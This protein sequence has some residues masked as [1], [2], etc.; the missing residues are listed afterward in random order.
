[1]TGLTYAPSD[2][3]ATVQPPPELASTPNILAAFGEAVEAAGL[4]GESRA[5]KLCYL[6]VTTRLLDRP[7]SLAL[8]GPSAAGKSYLLETVLGFFPKSAYHAL[9]AMSDRA[10]AYDREPLRH[11]ML[12][13]YEAA[14]LGSELA[15]YLVRSL[16]SEGRVRYTTV[17]KTKAGLQPRT[18]EREGPTGLITTTTAVRLHP[19]NETRLL[20]LT[21]AD[22]AA[23]TKAV[24][25]AQARAAVDAGPLR[26]PWQEFQTWLA[27]ADHETVIP[28]AE[29]LAELVPPVAVRLRRD[30]LA[31]LSLIRANALL[32]QVHRARDEVGRVVATFAD[33]GAVRELIADLI[34]DGA[35]QAVSDSVRQTVAA[36]RACNAEG[37]PEVTVLEV[38]R[39]IKIDKSAASRRVRVALER[40]HLRNL[41]DRRGRAARLVLGDPLPD[42][43]VILPEPERL[44]GC[45][46]L[47][48]DHD[49]A[50]TA[51]SGQTATPGGGRASPPPGELDDPRLAD[52]LQAPPPIPGADGPWLQ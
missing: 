11:R 9:S 3:A 30:F 7:V 28:Y 20:S 25:L 22:S 16:L 44:H 32:H 5:A 21:I 1:M 17:E 46:G 37:K 19:E 23:Q 13:L 52:W 26:A 4:R 40:G 27:S 50:P 10:L 49:W 31:V 42:D 47:G 36:V 39:A 34:A 2:A 15:T 29:A 24:L 38:A 35:E 41:E 43:V 48:G 33:Y 18:I 12:I 8:K 6:V 14:G 51:G 45:S